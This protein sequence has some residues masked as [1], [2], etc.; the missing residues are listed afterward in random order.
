MQRSRRLLASIIGASA[1]LVAA[2]AT[3]AGASAPS[4]RVDPVPTTVTL[5]LF[6]AQLTVD[7]TTG[8]GGALTSV[9]VNPADGLTATTLR[10]NR[11]VFQNA[12]GT[13]SI[14]V[15]SDHGAQRT[16]AR[17]GSLGDISGSGGWSG[18][19][20]GTGVATNVTFTVAAAADGG[21]DIINVA[22][23][24]PT[25]VISPTSYHH[26]DEDEGES[27]QSAVAK[28]T[29]NA[30]GQTRSLYIKAE[31]ESDDGETHAKL[32][33]SLGRI[34]GTP[35]PV[36]QAIGDKTWTGLLCD[37]STATIGYTVNEDGSLTLGDV[38]PA[39][40]DSRNEDGL[41]RVT[42]S[43]NEAV[44]IMAW[45]GEDGIT[46]NVWERIRCLDAAD[47]TVNTPVDTSRDDDHE[48]DHHDGDEHED[49]DDHDDG[50]HHDDGGDHHRG[51]DDD[52]DGGDHGDD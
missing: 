33:I 28:V 7:V 22:S 20:F 10:P 25:A 14:S 39:A 24:D 42:F 45:L 41:I 48:G 2:G 34:H 31:V 26:D 46:V 5:P 13:G 43:E 38:S 6:G 9:I 50:D 12:D 49:D 16:S 1:L 8:P 17:A 37:G 19:V 4:P 32:S 18:D 21:P 40:I 44:K 11:V 23:D 35:L 29:F 30:P 27:E 51:G 3:T 15:G 47:P 52:R 36:E